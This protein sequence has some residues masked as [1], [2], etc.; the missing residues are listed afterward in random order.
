MYYGIGTLVLLIGII[1]L[2]KFLM[3]TSETK[4]NCAVESEPTPDDEK[5]DDEVAE[6]A[7]IEIDVKD[8]DKK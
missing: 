2:I 1:V 7:G 4:E 6:V 3:R 5:P 8:Q